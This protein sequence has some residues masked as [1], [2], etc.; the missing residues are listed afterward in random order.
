MNGKRGGDEGE[1]EDEARAAKRAKQQA[2][3]TDAIVAEMA[4]CNAQLSSQRKKRQISPSLASP[5]AVESFTQLSSQPL[6][7]TTKPGILAVDIHA[8]KPRI[9]TGGVDGSAV[10]FDRD[11]GQI[12]ASLVGHTKRVCAVKFV[13]PED[14]LLSASADKTV[15]IWRGSEDGSG[16]DCQHV[17]KD[18]AG[19][20]RAVT[21]HAT[22]KYFVSASADKT[23]AFVDIATG[24]CLTQVS[25]A[26]LSEGYTSA[27]FHPDGLI[28]GT[29]TAEA[30]VRIWDVKSQTNVAKFEGHQG[31]ITAISFSENGY[32]LATAASDGVKLWDLRKLKNF[33][34]FAP[35]DA[36]TPTN[37]VRFDYSGSYLAI[38]GSD[39]RVIQVG[40]VKQEWSS[41]KTLPDLSGTGKV[42][43]AEFGPDASYIA[44]A[45]MDRNLRIFGPPPA[46]KHEAEEES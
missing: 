33:R 19:E 4:A 37:S 27:S 6:H 7:K 28:L 1:A 22:N 34:T 10:V 25:D 5:S 8:L 14:V 43:C 29:G 3:I 32:F 30:T 36:D 45:A 26:T 13:A 23:W 24:A 31:A 16:Y 12:V 38:A 39:I 41:I 20:V 42:T 15:R 2:G 11:A 21:V 46:A 18:H 35:F 17:V 9:A 40:S 44:S